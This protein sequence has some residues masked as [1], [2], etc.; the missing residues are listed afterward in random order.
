MHPR[1]SVSAISAMR[2]SVTQDLELYRR[3]GIDQVGLSLA[4]LDAHGVDDAVALVREAGLRV[5]NLLGVRAFDL[6][7]PSAWE[8]QRERVRR[9]VGAAHA[10]GAEYLVLTTGPAGDL[11]WE[12]AASRL[13]TALEPMLADAAG[14]EVPVALEHTNPLRTDISFVHSLRDAIHLA[15]RPEL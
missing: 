3:A 10:V 8:S 6:A 15:R 9:A 1:L 2:W 13:A 14:Q 5:T 4:K 7:D 11:E 12:E